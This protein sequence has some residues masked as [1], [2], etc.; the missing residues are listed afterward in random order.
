MR[1]YGECIGI[2]RVHRLMKLNRLKAQVGYNT[3]RQR[4]GGAHIVTPNKLNREF[5]TK[6][7]NQA[8]VTDITYIKT[9]EGWLY[10]AVIVDL[11]SRRVI[12][13][14]ATTYDQRACS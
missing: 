7:P 13:F 14:D 3:P 8:W 11:F 5:N 6:R 12:G 1:E 9:H 10:L 2:N 4:S